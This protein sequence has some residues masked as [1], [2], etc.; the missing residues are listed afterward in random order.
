VKALVRSAADTGYE[1]QI[2]R[3]VEAV[4]ER[5]KSVL[6]GKLRRVYGGSLKGKCFGL[7]GLAFKPNTDDMREAPSL[8]I[9]EKLLAAGATVRAYDPVSMAEARAMLGNAQGVTLCNAAYEVADGADALLIVTEWQEFRSPDFDRLKAALRQPRI[10]DGRNLY[11]P[12]LLARLGIEYYAIGRGRPAP[13]D[14]PV[15]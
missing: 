3:A 10:F 8:V 12:Q 7:W 13:V 4:N 6:I 11:D 1:P 15:A 14:W 9:I 2:L 5:Q